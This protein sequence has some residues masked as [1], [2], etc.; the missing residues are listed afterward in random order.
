MKKLLLLLAFLPLGSFAQ[1]FTNT[2]ATP[3]TG[4]DVLIPIQVNGIANQINGTF[5]LASVCLDISHEFVE[6][7]QLR[8]QSPDG[9]I[10]DLSI[11]HGGNGPGYRNTCFMMNGNGGRIQYAPAPFTGT[12]LPEMSLNVF[13]DGSDPNGT[14]LLRI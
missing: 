12:Y 13:N 8:L 3:I 6:D 11:G 9:K 4:G 2:T 14:W 1:S 7:L 5:G 10:I